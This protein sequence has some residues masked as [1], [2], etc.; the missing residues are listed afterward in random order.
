MKLS[1]KQRLGLLN[2]LPQ[3]GNE[4]E[5]IAVSEIYK[6][7]FLSEKEQ[8]AA[9]FKTEPDGR[10]FWNKEEQPK[11]LSF[12]PV[13]ASLLKGI[14]QKLDEQ[15]QITMEILPLILEINKL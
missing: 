10:A 11:K 3:S 15:K 5:M 7:V 1:I 13:E 14:R 2:L 12:T 6:K 8:E 9:G 4:M